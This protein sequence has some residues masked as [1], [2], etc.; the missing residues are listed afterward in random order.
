MNKDEF[1]ARVQHIIN[2]LGHEAVLFFTIIKKMTEYFMK[3]D[4]AFMGLPLL[5]E[6]FEEV[7]EDIIDILGQE[8]GKRFYRA[9]YDTLPTETV[10]YLSV[11]VKL[12]ELGDGESF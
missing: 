3:S 8:E 7:G 12:F 9:I 1:E 10:H 11:M 2:T 4:E 5:L 6:E